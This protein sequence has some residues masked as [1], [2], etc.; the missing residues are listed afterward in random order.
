MVFRLRL[1]WSRLVP[2][3]GSTKVIDRFQSE[4]YA[5]PIQAWVHGDDL[6]VW[7]VYLQSSWNRSR[8]QSR[9]ADVGHQCDDT[10]LSGHRD[11]SQIGA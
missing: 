4:T 3:T 2:E 1:S 9:E 10:D 8:P 11:I 5:G 7:E 6:T